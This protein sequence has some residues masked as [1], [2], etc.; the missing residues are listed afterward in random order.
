MEKK[1]EM[2]I[3]KKKQWRKHKA[4]IFI[5]FIFFVHLILDNPLLGI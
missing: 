1:A 2:K 4:M 5:L 3:R